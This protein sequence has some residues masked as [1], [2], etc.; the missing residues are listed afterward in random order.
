MSYAVYY[1][2][3]APSKATTRIGAANVYG[4]LSRACPTGPV[5]A[6]RSR[7][8]SR[9]VLSTAASRLGGAHPL[10][11]AVR[12][13]WGVLVFMR[14]TSFSVGRPRPRVNGVRIAWGFDSSSV[15]QTAGS[16]AFADP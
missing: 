6:F 5:S 12:Y 15:A 16:S 14:A 10:E 13:P 11:G 8:T 3:V 4:T 7:A 9:M 1:S 2:G